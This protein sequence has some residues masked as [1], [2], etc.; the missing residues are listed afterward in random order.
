MG[1]GVGVGVVM[2]VVVR[3][4]DLVRIGGV[5]GPEDAASPAV[6]RAFEGQVEVQVHVRARLALLERTPLLRGVLVAAV[7]EERVRVLVLVVETAP[8]SA[9]RCQAARG[10]SAVG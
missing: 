6:E 1:V 10:R 8:A 7:F 3:R 4:V 9:E 2:R 5:R